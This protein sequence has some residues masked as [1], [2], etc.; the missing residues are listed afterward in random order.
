MM[1]PRIGIS[2]MTSIASTPIAAAASVRDD[3]PIDPICATI[4]SPSRCAETTK[5]ATH[6]IGNKITRMPSPIGMPITVSKMATATIGK[7]IQ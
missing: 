2:P 1:P 5:P 4:S 7:P 6:E 3:G